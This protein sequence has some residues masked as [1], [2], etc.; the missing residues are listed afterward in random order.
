MFSDGTSK[1]C[2]G[3]RAGDQK[4][5]YRDL[6]PGPTRD[7]TVGRRGVN[8]DRSERFR[9]ELTEERPCGRIREIRR[10]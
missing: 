8:R 3:V 5:K 10:E 7:T 2:D 1:E 6:N 4:G 9:V